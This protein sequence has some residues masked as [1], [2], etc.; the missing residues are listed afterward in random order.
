M[1][2][3]AGT[4]GTELSELDEQPAT[5]RAIVDA[6]RSARAPER[7]ERDMA[8]PG[9]D[10]R[11]L[12]RETY[13]RYAPDVPAP[14]ASRDVTAFVLELARALHAHGT[15]SHR[16]EVLLST[17]SEHLGTRAEFFST[18][19]SLMVGFGDAVDQQVHLLRVTPGAP[20]LGR[21]SRLGDIVRDVLEE[22]LGAAEGLARI[23]ALQDER[24]R[25]PGWLSLLA[26]VLSSAAVA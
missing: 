11:G 17:V 14:T 18:P 3:E 7:S 23:R 25:W 26:F 13:R 10:E 12:T 15:P 1:V 22:G 16:L 9:A 2:S 5:A 19:T 8:E 24:P 6:A 4:D 20:D 21:L